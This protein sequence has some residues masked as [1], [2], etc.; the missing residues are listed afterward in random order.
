MTKKHVKS[1]KEI[2]HVAFSAVDMK[3]SEKRI[4]SV[5]EC[6]TQSLNLIVIGKIEIE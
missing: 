4:I 6:L 2:F 5:P 1:S 3:V